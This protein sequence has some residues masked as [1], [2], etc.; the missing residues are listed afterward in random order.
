MRR[1][2]ANEVWRDYNDEGDS[3]EEDDWHEGKEEEME[4]E[5][6]EEE[7]EEKEDSGDSMC[8][9]AGGSDSGYS[10]S[11]SSSSSCTGSDSN[12]GGDVSSC[13]SSAVV[14]YTNHNDSNSE[15]SYY[16]DSNDNDCN[17][18]NSSYISN[19]NSDNSS[20]A[21]ISLD[22]DDYDDDEEDVFVSNGDGIIGDLGLLNDHLVSHNISTSVEITGNYSHRVLREGVNEVLVPAGCVNRCED[23]C[24]KKCEDTPIQEVIPEPWHPGCRPSHVSGTGTSSCQLALVP[25]FALMHYEEE[26][27]DDYDADGEDEWRE[28]RREE[29]RRVEDRGIGDETLDESGRDD[30][31]EAGQEVV[32]LMNLDG[33]DC[34]MGIGH[35]DV[36]EN[37]GWE[38]NEDEQEEELGGRQEKEDEEVEEEEDNVEGQCVDMAQASFLELCST[39]YNTPCN[40]FSHFN[41]LEYES[42]QM[43]IADN[44]E[45][46]EGGEEGEDVDEEKVNEVKVDEEKVDEDEETAMPPRPMGCRGC[47]YC[48]G[49]NVSF[50][51]D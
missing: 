14:S 7:E 16:Y 26:E 19:S 45:G 15:S 50:G 3:D 43:I 5:M 47:Q 48:Q 36:M 30:M 29:G 28:R 39:P 40:A 10:S 18:S 38:E 49:I 17:S 20:N 31:E 34:E 25:L 51:L 11:S 6:E 24:V 1:E 12:Y 41:E 33:D 32:A 23:K 8:G 4:E 44:E 37:A 2:E 35:D 27:D 22:E 42:I 46:R 13:Y 21:D 9:Q